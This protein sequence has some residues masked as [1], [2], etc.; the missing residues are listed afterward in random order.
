M[1][2]YAMTVPKRRGDRPRR[3]STSAPTEV[4]AP[5]PTARIRRT[6]PSR[7]QRR[8]RWPRR[9]RQRRKLTRDPTKAPSP[10]HPVEESG[11]GRRIQRDCSET[12]TSPTCLGR[13]STSY[14][15]QNVCSSCSV[16]NRGSGL[17]QGHARR[18]FKESELIRRRASP[19]DPAVRRGNE[20][21]GLTDRR[22]IALERGHPHVAARLE[23]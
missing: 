4:D 10:A 7:R 14:V 22:A 6:L 5:A 19:G 2:G 3:A 18:G 23:P 1:A 21:H 13:P 12:T 9:R 17:P 20:G 16:W 11:P 8:R 15:D